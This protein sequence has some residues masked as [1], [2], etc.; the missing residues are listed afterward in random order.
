MDDANAGREV[1]HAEYRFLAKLNRA[2]RTAEQVVAAIDRLGP[3]ITGV[4]LRVIDF[5]SGGGAVAARLHEVSVRMGKPL[6]V[7]ASDQSPVAV[8][9]AAAHAGGRYDTI[10]ADLLDSPFRRHGFD[11]AHCS[12]VL[13][14]LCD[15]DVVRALRS[16]AD[17][18]SE[19]VI[20]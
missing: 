1:I 12:L 7:T 13:H 5:G 10:R 20:W 6:A 8:E 4:P 3:S 2:G 11:V 17:A 14:H 19:L 16:M 9:Y 18:A 15:A